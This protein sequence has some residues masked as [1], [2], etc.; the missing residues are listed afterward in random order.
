VLR[1]RE[2]SVAERARCIA[3]I[4][5]LY[6][7]LFSLLCRDEQGSST[8]LNEACYMLWDIV[9]LHEDEGP[10]EAAIDEACLGALSSVLKVRHL[11]CQGSALHGLGHWQHLHPARVAE[12]VDEF[13]GS[14]PSADPEFLAYARAAREWQV[15]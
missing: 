12:I 15:Q 13:I 9:G 3:A 4:P 8:P 1:D 5:S 6:T 7:D 2:V 14:N 11:A 10:V